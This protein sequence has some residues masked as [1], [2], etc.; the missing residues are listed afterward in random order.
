[1]TKIESKTEKEYIT[2]HGLVSMWPPARQG[3]A[4]ACERCEILVIEP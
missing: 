2:H 1:M 4:A 3:T